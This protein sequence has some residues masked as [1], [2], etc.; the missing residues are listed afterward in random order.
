[1]AGIEYFGPWILLR[2][3]MSYKLI[4]VIKAFLLHIKTQN[5]GN[6]AGKLLKR[7]DKKLP[8]RPK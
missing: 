6:F 2:Y 7:L 5:W 4:D 1:M 3:E 8:M